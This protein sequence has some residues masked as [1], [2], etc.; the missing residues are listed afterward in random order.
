MRGPIHLLRR[1]LPWVSVA[2]IAAVAYDAW[3]FYGRWKSARDAEKVRQ[4]EEIRRARQ[5]IDLLGGTDF[6]IINF[7][8]APRTIRRGS[9]ASICFGVYGAKRLRIEP[10]LG[11]LHPAVTGCEEV[12]P[13]KDTEYKLTAEDGAGHT[14]TASLV[15]QVVR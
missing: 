5:S 8:A 11:E 4:A 3:I 1:L 6:R 2:V 13:R 15:I 12:A 10:G 14:A 7:Y 9:R